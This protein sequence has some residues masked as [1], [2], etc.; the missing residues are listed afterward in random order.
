M[1]TPTM[2]VRAS[3][4]TLLAWLSC[5]AAA[6]ALDPTIRLSQY[7]HTAWR[8]R[9]GALVGSPFAIA[10][11][12]DGYLWIGTSNGLSRFDGVRFTSWTPPAG[13]Q[14]PS[15]IVF[16]LMTARDG[17][18]WIGTDAGL[19]RWHDQRLTNYPSGSVISILE[20][21]TGQIWIMRGRLL[22]PSEPVCQVTPVLKCYG[23]Q[24][25]I[26]FSNG[27]ALVEDPDGAIWVGGDTGFVKWRPGTGVLEAH[28]PEGLQANRGQAG[29]V[30]LGTTPDGNRWV[31]VDRAGPGAG[32]QMMDQG[33][34]HPFVDAGWNSSSVA[35]R[36]VHVDRQG[37]VWVGTERNGIYRIYG[38]HMEHFG[39]ADGLSED[40]IGALFEDHEGTIWVATQGGIDSFW[41]S[42]VVSF[43]AAEGVRSG[44][45]SGV[46]ASR[47]G[48]LWLGGNGA[49][50]LLR[51]GLFSSLS[52]SPY[53]PGVQVTSILEDHASRLWIGIDDTMSL[54]ENGR[55]HRVT[56]PDGHSVGLITSI[57][58][59]S[60]HRIWLTSK[61]PPR[62]LL[63][64][65]D[66]MIA[67]DIRIPGLPILRS[68]ATDGE[69][70]WMGSFDG[71][72]ARYRHDQLDMIEFPDV[73]PSRVDQVVAV[74]DG[75]VL[76]A[77][78]SALLGWRDGRRRTM[79][80]RN[81][82]PCDGVY[83]L[84]FDAN[85]ALWLSTP[86]GFVQIAGAEVDR[87]WADGDTRLAYRLFDRFDGA[88][89]SPPSFNPVARTADGR[90]WFANGERLQ[91]IDPAH[92]AG[93]VTPPPVQ[94]EQLVADRRQ[95]S[96]D[97]DLYLPALTRDVEIDYTALSF[98]APQ[99]VRFRYRLEGRDPGWQ[100]A[101]ARREAFFSDLRPGT[102]RFHVIAAN[103]DGVW[104]ERGAALT[105]TI[106]AAW[107]QTRLFLWCC[108]VS[109][110]AMTSLAYRLR[111][112]QL[113]KSY[114]IQFDQRLSE[115]TRIA[116]DLHDTFLQSIQGSK[117]V[118]DDALERAED[119][120]TMRQALEKL[121]GWLARA[122]EEG[123]SALNSLRTSTTETNDLA[124][125]LSRATAGD[126]R[127]ASM[128]VAFSVV[129]SAKELHP[130]VRDEIYRVGSEAIRN[131][132]AHSAATHL[133]VQ[134][135]YDK[136]VVVRVSDNGIGVD[137]SI[138]MH[139]K[140]GHFGLQG[141]RE[142]AARIGARW[143]LES[144]SS[145]TVM[146]LVVPG[147]IAF[148]K[149]PDVQPVR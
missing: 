71:R 102:Y 83:S 46:A 137:P 36:A 82:L 105:F 138:V 127:P 39:R 47:D 56:K 91:M 89:T 117:I 120:A 1:V 134:L 147:S 22:D 110:L 103:S 37:A 9:D 74:G 131:A 4:L 135:R 19:S 139:G 68:L 49:L 76:G 80:V 20:D 45:V 130:I 124:A 96:L 79:T 59:D 118:V 125:A 16:A 69:G 143:G 140:E 13:S 65:R 123:R 92:L 116:R 90:L 30:G 31:G 52:L 53:P 98:I 144:T 109:T 44:E 145:G 133:D 23:Q 2:G 93:N 111:V 114:R 12:P 99:K 94:I 128:A 14:L 29:I 107:Y 61:G 6:W 10:Q 26:P 51:G 40:S 86:C 70:M 5:V 38:N 87:W 33:R 17:S 60:E 35:V 78:A 122:V 64:I 54:Y 101:G 132:F 34:L 43:T 106:A 85:N 112:R 63:R 141:M 142:R 11:T 75:S 58:E 81:G 15:P 77:T 28:M 41:S 7:M 8:L 66:R 104:N 115:R 27:N 95:Y 67:E 108:I 55:F 18:L 88:R 148:R 136:D 57:A 24:D 129:G 73:P 42:R 72:I 25:G 3:L 48:T 121:S 126:Q 62:A 21:H 97:H 113:A 119:P 146:T 149:T 32:L 50:T 100:D 84:I